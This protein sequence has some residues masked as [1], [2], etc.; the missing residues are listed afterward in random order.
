MSAVF[1]S[2]E[3]LETQAAILAGGST[4][5]SE[6]RKITKEELI[7]FEDDIASEFNKGKI[8]APIH[9][10]RGNEDAMIEIFENVNHEDW[11]LCSWRNHYQCL[12]RGVPKET[13]KAEIM[14]GRSISLCFPEYRILSSAIVTGVLPIAVGIALSIKRAG[15]RNRVFCFMGEMT[16]ETG[17]A[18]ECIKYS[19]NHDLPVCWIIEDNGKSVCTDT[20]TVWNQN[21]LTFEKTK[22]PRIIYYKYSSPYPHAGA[23]KRVQF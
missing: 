15:K 21:P 6:T 11:V 4:L 18:H 2:I 22:S 19:E 23:G 3:G 20:R 16:S 12:L 1:E 14:A 7:A 5:R 17:V 10:Y 9:L 13:I 8:R